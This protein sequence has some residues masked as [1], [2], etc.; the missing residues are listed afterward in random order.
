MQCINVDAGSGPLQARFAPSLCVFEQSVT[1]K[2]RPDGAGMPIQL[3]A[4]T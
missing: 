4:D 3:A 2:P 1:S